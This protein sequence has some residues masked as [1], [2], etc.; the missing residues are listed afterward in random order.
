MIQKPFSNERKIHIFLLSF[1]KK[2]LSREKD[3]HDY[4]EFVLSNT[5]TPVNVLAL[6]NVISLRKLLY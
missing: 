2:E 4:T 1:F 5:L 3:L 6:H